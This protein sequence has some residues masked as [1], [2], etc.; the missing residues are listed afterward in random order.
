[1]NSVLST[2]KYA[3]INISDY[4]TVCI[5]TSYI[6]SEQACACACDSHFSACSL[7]NKEVAPLLIG[8]Q[9]GRHLETT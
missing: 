1:M 3:T 8:H 2:L 4:S 7:V 6:Y 5:L 9:L